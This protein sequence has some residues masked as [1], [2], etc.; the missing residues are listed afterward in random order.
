MSALVFQLSSRADLVREG[1]AVAFLY[2][3]PNYIP[4]LEVMLSAAK[5][6]CILCRGAPNLLSS[7]LHTSNSSHADE[8]AWNINSAK[9]SSSSSQF[10]TIEM[11][12]KFKEPK[13]NNC[14]TF[15]ILTP[16][17]FVLRQLAGPSRQV[18]ELRLF[19]GTQGEGDSFMAYRREEHT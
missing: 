3:P 18:A 9:V 16:K 17:S 10:V 19:N 13:N 12:L 2:Q 6:L 1:S 7:P 14:S 8:N 11:K 5:H 15:N 4:T